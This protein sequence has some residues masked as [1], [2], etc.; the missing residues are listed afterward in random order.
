MIWNF[1]GVA[2][3]ELVLNHNFSQVSHN[4]WNILAKTKQSIVI[5][6]I[7]NFWFFYKKQKVI[8]KDMNHG[9]S[10]DML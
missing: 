5:G 2:I 10:S 8:N 4:I 1:L 7:P 9:K 6:K 3:K